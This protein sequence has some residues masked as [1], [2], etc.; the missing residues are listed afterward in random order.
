MHA[1]NEHRLDDDLDRQYDEL[2]ELYGKPLEAEHRGEFLAIS[3]QGKTMLG[4]TLRQVALQAPDVLG[5]G[6]FVYQVG[7]PAVGK[8]R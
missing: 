5:P 4:P 3:P 1:R 7:E 2:Y 8:W 6:V